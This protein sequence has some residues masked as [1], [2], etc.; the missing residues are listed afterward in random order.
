MGLT[1]DWLPATTQL[2][3]DNPINENGINSRNT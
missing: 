3:N 2:A 1:V